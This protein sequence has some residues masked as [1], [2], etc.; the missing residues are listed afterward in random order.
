MAFV[1][2]LGGGYHHDASAC[3]VHDGEVVAFAEEERFTRRKHNRHS[4]SC[5]S[6]A[7]YCLAE[8]GIVLADVDEVGIGWNYRWPEPLDHTEDREVISELLDPGV[9]GHLPSR[10]TLVPHHV[11]HAASAFYP[12]GFRD[13]A[14]LVVDGSG[15]GVSTTLARGSER[16]L[17]LR[18][19]YPY[20]QS[21]GWFY[22][23]VAEHL[24]LGSWTSAGKLM[25]LA[26]H[27]D[28]RIDLPF[29]RP[30]PDGY[31]IDLTRLGL[32]EDLEHRYLDLGF[33]HE[34]KAGYHRAFADAGVAQ[35]APQR[36]YQ[37]S[38]GR[39]DVTTIFDRAQRD[40]AASAQQ[41][42][43]DCLVSLAR[44]A[45]EEAESERLCIAGGVGLNCTVN[46]KLR[47]LSGAAELFVQPVSSDAGIALGVAL[48]LAHR[49]GE[50]TVPGPPMRSVAL[51]P[52]FSDGEISAVLEDCGIAAEH[53][54]DSLPAVAAEEMTRGAVIGWFQGRMEVGPRALGQRSILANPGSR[55][56]RDHINSSI[57]RREMW[58]PLAPSLLDDEAGRLLDDERPAHFMNVAVSSTS[59]ARDLVPAAVHIDGSVRPQIVDRDG[60]PPF[61]LLLEEMAGRTGVGAVL[62]TSFNHESEP[63]VCTPLDALRTF[64]STPLDA[65]ALG[66]YLVRKSAGGR[67]S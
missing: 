29:V 22:E 10:L 62:N 4:Q 14:V 32:S 53:Y 3:L 43:E 5:S 27:G 31:S 51:G 17:V 2:G 28:P 26:A 46:G 16:G 56:V 34:L 11:A 42:L 54:G 41:C 13:A 38:S 33:Y 65:L 1:L 6:A 59:V 35:Q 25:G 12:S 55:S 36:S 48:E 50:V 57:K 60:A 7:A 37:P 21:L 47:R 58:R 24:G 64:Y 49:R 44:S 66:G 20:T 52:G 8:A 23:T 40:L 45:L 18:R 9:F 15:D 67:S 30:E 63:V 19:Q 61:R 39:F